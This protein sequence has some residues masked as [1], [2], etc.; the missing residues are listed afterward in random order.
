MSADRKRLPEHP[1]PNLDFKPQE[2]RTWRWLAPLVLVLFGLVAYG[3]SLSTPFLFDDLD[4]ITRNPTIK[5]LGQLGRVLSPPAGGQGVMGRPM[6]NLSLA[7]NYAVGGDRVEGYHALNLAIHL[8]S[9]LLLFGIIRRTLLA[10]V[11]A[12]RFTTHARGLAWV[13]ALIWL[14]HPLLT[15]S[16]TCIIQR[17]ES[18]MGLFYLATLYAS[19]R[20]MGTACPAGWTMLAGLACLAGMA[21]KEVMVS[22]PLIVWLY[23][24]TFA[25]GSF[26][27]AWRQRRGLYVT[28][29]ATWAILALLV[30]S[31][32]GNRGGTSGFGSSVT[33]WAYLGTQAEAICRYLKLAVWP[34]PLIVDY[35]RYLT[36][37]F[38]IVA[39]C[40][41]VVL[42]LVGLTLY[43]LVRRPVWGFV[44][45]WFFCILAPSSS[46]IPLLTQTIAE[47]RMYLPLAGIVVTLVVGLFC[48]WPRIFWPVGV[49]VAL[50]F[51]G[52]TRARNHDYRSSRAIWE[53]TVR[54]WP[55]QMRSLN[56]LA[57]AM[58]EDPGTRGE[59]AAVME[60]ALRRAQPAD[61]AVAL[62]NLGSLLAD[63]PTRA[64]EAVN[65]FRKGLVLNS[66]S[67]LG[68]RNLGTLL[69]KQPGHEQE[70]LLELR[71]ALRLEPDSTDT[72]S[73]LG[74]LLT[75]LPGSEKEGEAMLRE[76]LI[77]DPDLFGAAL[78]LGTVLA[79]QS[80]RL[81]EAMI[82]LS[83]AEVLASNSSEA[84]NSLGAALEKIP[85]QLEQALAAYRRAVVLQPANWRARYNLAM[86][87]L[88]QG[89]IDEAVG[90]LETVTRTAPDFPD[91]QTNL[92]LALADMPGRSSDA[93]THFEAAAR[94]SPQSA[95]AQFN[96]GTALSQLPGRSAD[97]AQHLTRAVELKPDDAGA[98]GRLGSL[99]LAEAGREAEGL[100]HLETAVRLDPKLAEVHYAIAQYL[101]A[102]TGRK[103][104]G[105]AHLE[106]A[107]RLAPDNFEM[108]SLLDQWRNEK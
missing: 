15:E 6:V 56:N 33:T 4:S 41:L 60:E 26:A 70:A 102:K 23:D 30:I 38:V 37:S 71:T 24:R 17:T 54:K 104:E 72:L 84:S 51:V 20:A 77:L 97:A 22:A 98:H 8:L 96:L 67:A 107:A 93:L 75:R 40:G 58:A 64:G 50:A 5:Q 12:D 81:D 16:V 45:S 2:G 18:L 14:V 11:F 105:L 91:A 106:A 21:T 76:A 34:S 59:A 89:K 68:H 74:N 53:D 101:H 19:M 87:L 95:D 78:D 66:Q 44:G 57:V 85:G 7:L 42:G 9:A 43:G 69:G 32:G 92:A 63:S 25:A 52:L 80:G 100:A 73:A 35:G 49:A 36:Q 94:I 99:L 108:R 83:R 86:N 29:G 10:P 79:G 47:H 28:L 13:A 82:Y 27:A 88:N 39:L 3:N 90:L 103:H 55:G 48:H 62:I 31:M 1:K 46:F 65:L 61:Q